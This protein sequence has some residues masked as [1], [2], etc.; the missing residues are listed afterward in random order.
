MKTEYAPNYKYSTIKDIVEWEKRM[1][2]NNN[3]SF[4]WTDEFKNVNLI[5]KEIRKEKI[6][7]TQC[8]GIAIEPHPVYHNRRCK[9]NTSNPNGYCRYHQHQINWYK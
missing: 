5:S 8:L 7:K 9:L 4:T 1:G 6:K 2:F 3:L